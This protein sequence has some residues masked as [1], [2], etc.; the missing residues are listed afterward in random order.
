MDTTPSLPQTLFGFQP[1]RVIGEGAG[2]TIYAVRDPASGRTL[3][4]KHVVR[5]NEK[6]I[7]FVEQLTNEMDVGKKVNHP[8]VRRIL[9]V[10]LERSLLWKV[11]AAALLMDLFDGEPL[12]VRLPATNADIVKVFIQVAEG[13]GA[14]HKAGFVHCD[15]KPANILMNRDGDVRII[16]L[17]QA[18]PIGTKKARI[19]G[20]PDYISP[21][22]VKLL[23]V[24][25][26]TDV[27]SLGATMYWCLCGQKLPTL[28]TLKKDE[29]S[30]LV[31]AFIKAPHE[32][33]PLV[34]ENLSNFVMEMARVNPT[35]RPKD[36]ASVVSR[37][38]IILHGLT[39]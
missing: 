13:L 32:I 14:M 11:N 35:K 12:D 24:D 9:D 38:E 36:M 16:D 7:R 3:A 29:N 2:S 10:K 31:D 25:E 21:E 8:K 15:L 1:I 30:F 34:P 23:P 20:T 39:K 19:Q 27:Y 17:G 33:N 4:L 6:A 5:N 28:F 37:L 18:C 26:R 22:Q